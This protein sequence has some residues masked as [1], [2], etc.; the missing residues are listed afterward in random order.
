VPAATLPNT[1]EDKDIAADED[2]PLRATIGDPQPKREATRNVKVT[3]LINRAE[4][5]SCTI[6]SLTSSELKI[7]NA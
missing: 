2:E 1:T 3:V 5:Q 7:G 4:W 6:N